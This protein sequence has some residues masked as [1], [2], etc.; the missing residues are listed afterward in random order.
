MVTDPLAS[1]TGFPF[2]LFQLE[3]THSDPRLG[4]ERQRACDL[5]YLRHA[6][7]KENG[8]VGWRCPAEPAK[9][10]LNK[11]GTSDEALGRKCVCNGLLA[12]VGLAQIRPDG[13]LEEALLTS[14][15]DL[16]AVSQ[17]IELHGMHY[18]AGDVL[19]FLQGCPLTTV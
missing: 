11:G 9:S 3:G 16:R 2:K 15:A 13:K 10:F 17:L 18:S 5:G 19:E 12:N 8:R 6:Y 7:A 1:P 14:G 4:R